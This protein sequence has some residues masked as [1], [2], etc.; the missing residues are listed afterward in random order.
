MKNIKFTGTIISQLLVVWLAFFLMVFISYI[1]VS[2]IVHNYLTKEA[3][4]TLS[5]TQS[6]ITT[7]L[8]EAETILQTVSQSILIMILRGDP[9]DVILRHMTEITNYLSNNDVRVSGFNGVF[10]FFD[11]F[12]GLFLDGSGWIPPEDFVSQDR[13]W[14]K[15]GV[16]AKGGIGVSTPYLSMFPG[17][18]VVSYSRLIHDSHGNQ[19]GVVSVDI[20]LDKM[21]DYIVDTRLTDGG[22]GIMLNE[23]LEVIASLSTE[24]IGKHISELPYKGIFFVAGSLE[25]SV[26]IVEY[27]ISDNNS[28]SDYIIFTKQLENGWHIGLFTPLD[29]YYRQVTNMRFFIAVLGIALAFALT[30]I[31]LR[32]ASAKQKADEETLSAKAASKAKGDFLATMSHEMRS[33]LNVIIGLS[34]IEMLDASLRE[35]NSA[36]LKLPEDRIDNITQIHR[37]G[38]I[39]LGIINDILDISKIEAGRFELSPDVYDTASMIN[40]TVVLCKVRIGLTPINFILEIDSGFPRKLFGDELRVK[41]ILHNLLSNAIKYTKKGTIT[42]N[43]SCGI[44]QD[45]KALLRFSVSDTGIGIR[46]EDISKLF[47]SYTQ[48]DTGTRRIAEGTGLGLAIVKNL[49]EIMEGGTTVQSEYGKGSC[50]TAEIIQGIADIEPIGNEAADNLRNFNF[51]DKLEKEKINYIWLPETKALIVDDIPANQ[52]VTKGLL[53]PYGLQIDTAASGKEAIELAKKTNYSII[54]M[55]HMMPE[56]DG[57]EAAAIIRTFDKDIPIISMT[58][59]AT[60]GMREFYLDNGFND[61]ISKPVIPKTLHEII[62]KWINAEPKPYPAN[63]VYANIKPGELLIPQSL[64]SLALEQSLDVL[65]H[66]RAAFESGREID[67]E[68]YKKFTDFIKTFDEIYIALQKRRELSTKFPA[69]EESNINHITEKEMLINYL[70]RLKNSLLAGDAK[71]ANAIIGEIGRLELTDKGR[72]LYIKLYDLMF[73]DKTEEILKLIKEQS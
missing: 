32:I 36:L 41:Q 37:S 33:P 25:N 6:R 54:F 1:F 3:E 40:D 18:L 47:S 34:E 16:E 31:L 45:K 55:D 44:T 27:V 58:A 7:D 65:N 64:S 51:A 56:M 20:R 17:A 57:V 59:N 49:T 68:Y 29:K 70:S 23:N 12:G 71:D 39:L 14:Y 19:L 28:N 62:I 13:P 22:F 15:A 43:V 9:A 48:L 50:F 52:K 42:L 2:D 35:Q 21:A 69:A 24:H 11:V 46:E 66:Y 26:D 67:A 10:G 4:N 63:P 30:F 38:T 60:R 5:F 8:R 72:D 53:T 73:E 61:Y